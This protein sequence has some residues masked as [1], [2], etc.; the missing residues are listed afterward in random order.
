MEKNKEINDKEETGRGRPP[1]YMSPMTQ[2]AI[3]LPDEMI[4]WLKSGPASM[5]EK[6][7]LLIQQAMDADASID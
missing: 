3:W 1:L 6:M 7:R 5:S 4:A 2:T